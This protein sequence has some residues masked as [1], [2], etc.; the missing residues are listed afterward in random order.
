[1][2][3]HEMA[4]PPEEVVTTAVCFHCQQFVE[5]ALKA[6]LV[7]HSADFPRTHNLEYLKELCARIDADFTSLDVEPLELYAVEIRYP[8][9]YPIPMV[10]EA[11]ECLKITEVIRE[12]IEQK[13]GVSFES[14]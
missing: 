2:A 11:A 3:R 14:V 10:E 13:L 6:F 1:M 12:F 4:L 9:D 5:K 8:G 7:F